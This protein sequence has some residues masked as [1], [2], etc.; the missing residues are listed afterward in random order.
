MIYTSRYNSKIIG[1][2]ISISLYPPKGFQGQHL[3]ILAP[4]P[5]VLNNYKL[6]L[7]WDKYVTGYRE[8]VVSRMPQIKAWLDSLTPEE[9][10]TLLCYEKGEYCHRHL[11][12]K[13]VEKHRPDLW[14]GR[15]DEAPKQSRTNLFAVFAPTFE[16]E[17]AETGFPIG[18]NVVSISHAYRMKQKGVVKQ[19]AGAC[20]RVL[21]DDGTVTTTNSNCLKL[22]I[23]VQVKSTTKAV[24]ASASQSLFDT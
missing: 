3:H 22:A 21:W 10:V 20:V 13:L 17:K 23:E 14:G 1:A 16:Q 8:N 15:L 5:E 19:N 6:D 7:D 9:N 24:T 2:A 4:T 18:T 11:V 12:Q